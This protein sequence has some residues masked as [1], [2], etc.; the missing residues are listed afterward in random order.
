M[1]K[2]LKKL[3]KDKFKSVKEGAKAE[4]A[5]LQ[6]V[7]AEVKNAEIEKGEELT[8]T[9]VEKILRKEVKKLEDAYE[10]FIEAGRDDLAEREK[11]QKELVEGYLPD[12]MSEEDIKKFVDDKIAEIGAESLRDMGKV[13]SEVMK[14]LEGKADG[15]EVN[16]IVRE[17]LS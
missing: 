9:E 1:A 17:T 15:S 5:I 3:T 6:L 16:R 11:T 13:M 7:T 2:L 4:S 8:D 10:Q 12:L 14:E